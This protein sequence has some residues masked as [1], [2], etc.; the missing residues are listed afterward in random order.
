L[1]SESFCT[2]INFSA[3][4]QH[5]YVLVELN[6][7]KCNEDHTVLY[8]AITIKKRRRFGCYTKQTCVALQ[9]SSAKQSYE[10]IESVITFLVA[11]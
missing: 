1:F 5:R 4:A 6:C 8:D 3:E 11:L 9:A 7:K 10:L 2:L